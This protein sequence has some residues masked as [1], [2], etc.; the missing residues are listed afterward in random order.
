MGNYLFYSMGKLFCDMKFLQI[1]SPS[2]K[3]LT[4]TFPQNIST[5][6][7]I[8]ENIVFSIIFSKPESKGQISFFL[9]HLSE[10]ADLIE[11]SYKMKIKAKVNMLSIG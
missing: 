4:K 2:S 10:S 11:C 3:Q 5:Y 9:R 6:Y 1:R 7:V 8:C